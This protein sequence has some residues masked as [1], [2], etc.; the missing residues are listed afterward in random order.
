MAVAPLNKFLTIAVPVAPGEQTI[1]EA[2][3]GTSAIVLYAQVSNVGVGTTYPTVSFTHRRTSVATRTSGN[4]RNNRIIK[5]AEIPP[6]DA[7][8]LVD[9]RLVLER[10]AVVAD[11]IVLSGVQTGITTIMNVDYDDTSGI[12]TVKTLNDHNFVVNDQITMA[13]IAFTCSGTYGLTTSIFPEPQAAFQVE[14]VIN[15]STFSTNVGIVNDLSHFYIP[16][17]HKFVRADSGAINVVGGSLG[18]FTPSGSLYNAKTG[19]VS[20]RIPSHGLTPPTTHTA[21]GAGTTYNPLTGIMTV[22][23]S[24]TPSPPFQNGEYV[25][26]EDG[27]L[28]FGCDYGGAAG[29]DAQKTYPRVGDPVSGKFIPISNVTGSGNQFEV[30]VGGGRGDY[31][32]DFVTGQD[33]TNNSIIFGGNYTH[34]WTGGQ[35]NGVVR[36]ANSTGTTFNVTAATYTPSS[37]E[38]VLTVT[39]STGL[40]ASDVINIKLNSLTFSCA[41]DN[42]SSNHTYPRI[43]DPIMTTLGSVNNGDAD[44]SR[45]INCTVDAGTDKITLNVGA[46]PITQTTPSNATYNPTTGDMVLTIPE[47]YNL[48]RGGTSLPNPATLTADAG[49]SYNHSTGVLSVN[50]TVNHNLHTGSRIRFQ[51]G[52]ISFTCTK[53]GGSSPEAYPRAHDPESR[54]WLPITWV[55]A[56]TFTVQ[57]SPAGS[58]GQ[59]AHTY[60]SAVA[61]AIE[62]AKDSIKIS[63]QSIV[64]TCDKDNYATKH[65]YPRPTDPFYNTSISIGATAADSITV[66]VGKS[67]V[68]QPHKFVSAENSGIKRAISSI[69]ISQDSLTYKCSQDGFLTEHRYPRSTDPANNAVLGVDVLDSNNISAYVGIST[70]GGLVGPLQMEFICSILEN[71]TAS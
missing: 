41:M 5:D 44:W 67:I 51:D 71:S 62:V 33:V 2:P 58:D 47:G 57:I 46:S 11:S 49:S 28:T 26:F 21:T 4:I 56:N 63:N 14:E 31:D 7:L 23:V 68:N 17:I 64:F 54:K 13:G 18:P 27:S 66:F 36:D 45:T 9:G 15:S 35:A 16:S 10:T 1:Y 43:G 8:I 29:S 6:N 37:G 65:A 59:Y 52:A 40:T 69:K 12:A 50:T 3:V 32:H 19:I 42:N 70:A 39:D 48:N 55:D 53:D 30:N 34:V 25:K 38:L 22:T 20:F 60:N 24:G 61:D